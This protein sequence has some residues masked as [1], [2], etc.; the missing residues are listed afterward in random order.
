MNLRLRSILPGL[1]VA[2]LA[3]IAAPGTASAQ[4]PMQP[5]V[6]PSR[7]ESVE[8]APGFAGWVR[9]SNRGSPVDVTDGRVIAG[10][11]RT[12]TYFG[13]LDFDLSAIPAG[14]HVATVELDMQLSTGR[15]AGSFGEY[16]VAILPASLE[17]RWPNIDYDDTRGA[18]TIDSGG[19]VAASSIRQQQVADVTRFTFDAAGV[20]AA[21]RAAGGRLLLRIDGPAA[22]GVAAWETGDGFQPF[23]LP[24][25]MRPTLRVV[26]SPIAPPPPPGSGR[27]T[28]G[29]ATDALDYVID[30]RL[31]IADPPVTVLAKFTVDNRTAS[32][33]VFTGSPQLFDFI[34]RDDA[35]TEVWRWSDGMAWPAVLVQESLQNDT[36]E[37]EEVLSIRQRSGRTLP[38]GDYVLEA[39]M[40]GS[41]RG[42]VAAKA[43]FTVTVR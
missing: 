20:A 27:L 18:Q 7:L 21:A 28:V 9:S 16:S 11:S 3:A 31:P 34:V 41:L 8:T 24:V 39:T 12:A 17:A 35:G 36:W 23:W 15:W 10:R 6:V 25:V 37:F 33:L 14:A 13:L 42:K 22:G 19:S 4:S 1:A 30:T 43:P 5:P 32:P 2:A 26:W 29:V 38:A 40:M